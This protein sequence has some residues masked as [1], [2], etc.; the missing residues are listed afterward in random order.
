MTVPTVNP[1]WGGTT[2]IIILLTLASIIIIILFYNYYHTHQINKKVVRQWVEECKTDRYEKKYH[3]WLKEW[4]IVDKLNNS[5]Q[6]VV[7]YDLPKDIAE[8]IINYS[9]KLI[10]EKRK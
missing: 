6:I 4:E 7:V 1:E 2:M 3:R 5:Q 9:L 8:E 10:G